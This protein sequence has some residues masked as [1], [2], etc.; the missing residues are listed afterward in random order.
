MRNLVSAG[1]VAAAISVVIPTAPS[2]AA[3]LMDLPPQ[4]VAEVP[5]NCY[6][7]FDAGYSFNQTPDGYYNGPTTGEKID[8]SYLLET[9]VG[10]GSGHLRGE[11]LFTYRGERDITVVPPVDDI[12]TDLRTYTLMVNMFYDFGNYAGFVPYVGAGMGLGYHVLSDLYDDINTLVPQAGDEELVF[13]WSLM[14]GVGYN[15][16]E[17]FVLDVGYRYVD[18]GSMSSRRADS[19]WFV[20]PFLD[21]DDLEAHEIKAGFRYRFG[22]CCQV[23]E[24][25]K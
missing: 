7:R 8:D 6:F 15:I 16:S 3:D 20:N 5:G 18:L 9:G 22:G 13:V 12:F 14:A 23:V 4:P 2:H 10:C 24:T 25:F 11:L 21:L 17:N 19:A 1:I